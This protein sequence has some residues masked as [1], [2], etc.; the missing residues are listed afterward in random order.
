M[1]GM[2]IFNKDAALTDRTLFASCDTNSLINPSTSSVSATN[3]EFNLVK[4][5]WDLPKSIDCTANNIIQLFFGF[6]EIQKF[7]F[8]PEPV[9]TIILSFFRVMVAIALAWLGLQIAAAIRGTS[10]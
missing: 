3:T 6:N 2:P 1:F 8:L 7:L 9:S 10:L 5:I 4:L